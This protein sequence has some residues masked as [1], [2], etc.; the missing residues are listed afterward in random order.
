[1][2]R[3]ATKISVIVPV[4]NTE[5]YLDECLQSILSQTFQEFEILAV[6]DGS[7]DG[8]AQ[9]IQNYVQK[10]PKIV[11]AFFQENSGQSS[12]RNLAL[13]NA[14]GEYISF[15]DSDDFIGP[16]F[17]EQLYETAEKKSSDMVICNYTK[18][19]EDGKKRKVFDVNFVEGEVRI[20]SYTACNRLIRKEMLDK[21]QIFFKEGVIC[22]D[23]PFILKIE[24]VA[25]NIKTV[26]MASYYYRTNP[27]STTSSYGRKNYKMEQLPVD[28]MKEAVEFCKKNSRNLS[29]D[30]L[31]F[32]VCRIWTSLVFD[33]GKECDPNVQKNMCKEVNRFMGAY[34][35]DCVENA[36]VKISK[37]KNISKVQKVGTWIF[38][39]SY[40]LH[41][42][43]PAMKLYSL[44]WK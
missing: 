4:Y 10:Y 9:I 38:V 19:S 11:R 6:D 20:P 8:S 37:F 5:K 24:A 29:Y 21:Y 25:K 44:L 23:I 43:Y 1:M 7:I 39:Q 33:I 2:S 27:K 26:S 14:K 36:Y 3:M 32:L 13:R 31:E 22:E 16:Q 28:A 17:L 35:P 34:F 12:A 18:V 41:A 42:L 30:W 40:R 15:V